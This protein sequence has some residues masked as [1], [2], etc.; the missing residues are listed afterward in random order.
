[1]TGE[2]MTLAF[3]LAALWRAHDPQSVVVDARRWAGD[4]GL[5]T[6]DSK[7]A[8]AFSAENLV[9][10]DFQVRPTVTDLQRLHN[11]V[12]SERYVLIGDAPDRPEYVPPDRWEYLSLEQAAGAAGW[13]IENTAT[14][15]RRSLA[16][17]AIQ[18]LWKRR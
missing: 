5:V 4:V 14:R 1:M 10:R 9:R 8:R 7:S 17:T 6:T 13:N 16:A 15:S 3:E 2:T 11:R 12:D 18:R